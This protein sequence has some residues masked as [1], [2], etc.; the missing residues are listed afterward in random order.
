M[1]VHGQGGSVFAVPKHRWITP[2]YRFDWFPKHA[3]Y[4]EFSWEPADTKSH[5][6]CIGISFYLLSGGQFYY[7]MYQGLSYDEF[8]YVQAQFFDYMEFVPYG[9]HAGRIVGLNLRG[10]GEWF[11]RYG[12]PRVT[13]KFTPAQWATF[14]TE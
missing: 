4:Q 13:N 2:D 8:L 3:D 12:R 9:Y 11:N 6:I 5:G 7:L 10:S 1:K 14:T